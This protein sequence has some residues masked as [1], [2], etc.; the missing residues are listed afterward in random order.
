M[1]INFSIMHYHLLQF[2]AL[3]DILHAINALI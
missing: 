2:N 1:E 3:H